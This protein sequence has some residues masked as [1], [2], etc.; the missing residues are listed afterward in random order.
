MSDL[1]QLQQEIECVRSRLHELVM[2][3]QGHFIDPE[4]TELSS[5]LD[6]LI[7]QYER[8]KMLL[9]QTK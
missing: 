2:A 3:K 1:K 7:V 6:N 5:Y 8:D 4:V 9:G